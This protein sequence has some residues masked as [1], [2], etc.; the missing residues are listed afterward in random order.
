VFEIVDAEVIGEV[1]PLFFRL[2]QQG[3]LAWLCTD[4]GLTVTGQSRVDASLVY[5]DGVEACDA[6]FVGGPVAMAW[7]R[8]GDEVRARARAT[9]N[10]SRRGATARATGSPVNSSSLPQWSPARRWRRS[11]TPHIHPATMERTDRGH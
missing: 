6:A 2:G 8:F 10:R 1:C 11:A 3:A 5:A 9:W 4:A 7:S